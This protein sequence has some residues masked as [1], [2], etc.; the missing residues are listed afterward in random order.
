MSQI[1]TFKLINSRILTRKLELVPLL[2]K[3]ENTTKN[4]VKSRLKIQ[5]PPRIYIR[6]FKPKQPRTTLL[7]LSFFFFFFFLSFL[8]SPLSRLPF[9]SQFEVTLHGIR[10][11]SSCSGQPTSPP[12]HLGLA[13][14]PASLELR[15]SDPDQRAMLNCFSWAG[16]YPYFKRS[17][18]EFSAK[19]L[20][21]SLY[22][23]NL[24]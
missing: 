14:L 5:N 7:S 22:T 17:S 11:R 6:V 23:L 13:Q 24:G 4:F 9:L 16:G 19:S 18:V 8:L 15:R 2:L 10:R 12:T 3:I 1:L 21:V 20:N